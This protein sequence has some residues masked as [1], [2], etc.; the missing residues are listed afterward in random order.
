MFSKT[1]RNDAIFKSEAFLKDGISFNIMVSILEDA[2]RFE[3]ARIYTNGKDCAMM[4]SSAEYPVVIWMDETFSDYEVLYDF[5]LKEF[6]DYHP[7][8]FMSNFSFYNFLN[9]GGFLE[10]KKGEPIELGSYHCFSLNKRAYCG[11]A[12]KIKPEEVKLIAQMI[13][14]FCIETGLFERP[15]S[16]ACLKEAQE[17]LEDENG[18]VWRDETGKLVSMLACKEMKDYIRISRVMT[19]KEERGKSYAKMLVH[20][21]TKRALKTGKKV[22]LFTNFNYNSSNKCYQKVGYEFREKIYNFFVRQ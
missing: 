2:K 18:Y 9:K 8:R 4:N 10:E 13:S 14:D 7:L 3:S 16:E 22:I 17:F 5:L 1:D 21:M 15:S 19:L 6:S 12:D 11:Y 20:F